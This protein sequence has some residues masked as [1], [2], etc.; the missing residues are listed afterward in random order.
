MSSVEP[1]QW[2]TDLYMLISDPIETWFDQQK[3]YIPLLQLAPGLIWVLGLLGSS[4]GII[5]MY[6]FL[7]SAPLSAET[8][9]ITIANYQTVFA[10]TYYLTVLL[11]S[12]LIAVTVTMISLLI[13]YPAAY[14]IAFMNSRFRNL[15]LLMLILPFWINLIIRTFAWQLIL[16]QSGLINYVLVSLVGIFETPLQLL[17]S[18]WA[19]I[20]GLVHVFMPFAVIPVYTSIQRIDHSHI[21]AA[22][23]LGANRL[24][25][26]Y[27]VTFPQT[28]PGIA[29]SSVIVFVLSFGSFVIPNMLGGQGNLMIGNIIA[30][31]FGESFDWALG[32]AMATL[33]IITV[34]ILVYIFNR[35]IGL[36][37]LYGSDAA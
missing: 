26:F 18:P 27:E 35:I 15:Y 33:F 13:A 28:L 8:P 2:V 6:S 23:N 36:R 21:E 19:V 9:V 4:V 29:A 25:T 37:S 10:T 16:G 31:L 3:S 12:F 30:Q 14:H 11:R 22:R 32:S 34:I 24:Q 5:L 7:E 1:R 17:Y 20:I